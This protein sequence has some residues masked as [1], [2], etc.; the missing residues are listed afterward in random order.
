MPAEKSGH[1]W[2]VSFFFSRKVSVLK[3]VNLPLICRKIFVMAESE[4]LSVQFSSVQSLSRVQ[5]FATP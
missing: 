1:N 5:L 2:K 4:E 3:K